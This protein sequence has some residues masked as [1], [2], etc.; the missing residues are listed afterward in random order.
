MSLLTGLGLG[1]RRTSRR[2]C[3]LLPHCLQ[4]PH[5]QSGPGRPPPELFW[6]PG[7]E[8]RLGET[9]PTQ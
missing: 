2:T 7:D 4:K 3:D 9:S 8:P 6:V 1:L 5:C